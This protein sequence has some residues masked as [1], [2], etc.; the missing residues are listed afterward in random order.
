LAFYSDIYGYDA[1]LQ[2]ALNISGDLSDGAIFAPPTEPIPIEVP[3]SM[4]EPIPVEA[5]K[6]REQ[7]KPVEPLAN[8]KTL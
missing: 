5:I 1:V 6:P 4:P 8:Y 3:E 7:I 2:E